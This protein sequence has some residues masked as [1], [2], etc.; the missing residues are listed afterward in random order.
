MLTTALCAVCVQT[1]R[2]CLFQDDVACYISLACGLMLR[3]VSGSGTNFDTLYLTQI[4]PLIDVNFNVFGKTFWW[5]YHFRRNISFMLSLLAL[6]TTMEYHVFICSFMYVFLKT[7]RHYNVGWF[8]YGR[9]SLLANKEYSLRWI[10]SEMSFFSKDGRSASMCANVQSCVLCLYKIC[11][12]LT[13][14]CFPLCPDIKKE[15]S[16]QF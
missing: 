5:S 9:G 7:W 6:A 13:E 10:I 4:I 2:Y 3:V 11:H 16:M 14:Q 1:Y 8:C 15:I 12:T